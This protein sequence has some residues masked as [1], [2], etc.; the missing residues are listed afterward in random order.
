MAD[1]ICLSDR[2]EVLSK[3]I[4]I[5]VWRWWYIMSLTEIFYKI[6]NKEDGDSCII[7]AMTAANEA[8]SQILVPNTEEEIC[9]ERLFRNRD[10]YQPTELYYELREFWENVEPY[11]WNKEVKELEGLWIIEII[12]EMEGIVLINQLNRI[13]DQEAKENIKILNIF[14]EIIEDIRYKRYIAELVKNEG[15]YEVIGMYPLALY[16]EQCYHPYR[17][18]L[19]C[20]MYEWLKNS[21]RIAVVSGLTGLNPYRISLYRIKNFTWK[22][23]KV[24]D[25]KKR[26]QILRDNEKALRAGLICGYV[27][28]ELWK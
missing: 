27:K 3:Q 19:L 2:L 26:S 4:I 10:A 16:N 7:D 23:S 28:E 12:Q 24:M 20:K 1:R 11:I 13:L 5:V 9:I 21:G 6:L 17:D 8:F 25:E 18:F 22:V 14:S 15:Q